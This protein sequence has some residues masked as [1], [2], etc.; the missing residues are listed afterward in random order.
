LWP[1]PVFDSRR[2]RATSTLPQAAEI[3]FVDAEDLDVDIRGLDAEQTV[4]HESPHDERAAAMV[5]YELR[6]GGRVLQRI[7]T[8]AVIVA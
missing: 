8:H 2:G 7:G 5:A 4:S 3:G 1:R 6:D